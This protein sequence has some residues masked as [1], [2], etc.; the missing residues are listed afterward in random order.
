MQ[1]KRANPTRRRG[2]RKI[3]QLATAITSE[4]IPPHIALQIRRVAGRFGLPPATARTIAR[5]FADRVISARR[6]TKEHTQVRSAGDRE[7][8][9]DPQ[10]PLGEFNDEIPL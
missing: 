1:L 3:D 8:T 7:R 2:A 6:A 9:L 5:L 10:Q 4:T